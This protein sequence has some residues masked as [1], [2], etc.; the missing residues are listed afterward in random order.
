MNEFGIIALGAV[1]GL[2]GGWLH[3]MRRAGSKW[4]RQAMLAGVAGAVLA[5]LAG[6]VTG[7]FYDGETLEWPVCASAALLVVAVTVGV[8]FRR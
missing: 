2:L 4:A 5:K 3:P 8:R 1:V 6:R 7:L